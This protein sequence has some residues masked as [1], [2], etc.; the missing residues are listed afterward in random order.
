MTAKYEWID[1]TGLGHPSLV[2]LDISDVAKEADVEHELDLEFEQVLEL[3]PVIRVKQIDSFDDVR[4]SRGLLIDLRKVRVKGME[5]R[6]FNKRMDSEYYALF[7][8]FRR[9]EMEHNG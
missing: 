1:D 2:Y 7:V 4:D 6:W 3:A 9:K 8:A 5:F